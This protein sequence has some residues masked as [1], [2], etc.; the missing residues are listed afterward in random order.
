MQIILIIS[1]I[2]EVGSDDE[3]DVLNASSTI[4]IE[5]IDADYVLSVRDFLL[6]PILSEIARPFDN[7]LLVLIRHPQPIDAVLVRPY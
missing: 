5:P 3:A 2:L 7:V 1:R 4:S 6:P